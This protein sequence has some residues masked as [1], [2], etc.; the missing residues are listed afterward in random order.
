MMRRFGLYYYG[1]I[2]KSIGSIGGLEQ[3]DQNDNVKLMA[4]SPS[5]TKHVRTGV[6]GKEN[7]Y[8]YIENPKITSRGKIFRLV[9][10]E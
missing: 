8:L 4:R 2:R 9:P 10:F 6:S 5:I 7:L 3:Y 1:L